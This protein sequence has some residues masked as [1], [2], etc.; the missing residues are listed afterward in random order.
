MT[1]RLSQPSILLICLFFPS[2]K[3]I[4]KIPF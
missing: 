2:L 3:V 4:I 1:L